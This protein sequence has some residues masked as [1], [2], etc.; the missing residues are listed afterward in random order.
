MANF[1]DHASAPECTPTV[2]ARCIRHPS[3]LNVD[4][5]VKSVYQTD[6]ENFYVCGVDVRK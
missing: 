1:C 2:F 6:T 4:I 5:Y 3:F